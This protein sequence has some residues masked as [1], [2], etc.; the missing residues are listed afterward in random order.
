MPIIEEKTLAELVKEMTDGELVQEFEAE[1]GAGINGELQS[2][3]GSVMAAELER[4]GLRKK[5]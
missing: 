1:N 3:A 5:S 4:R 2:G